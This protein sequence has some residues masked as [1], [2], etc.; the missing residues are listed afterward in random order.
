M[1][2]KNCFEEKRYARVIAIVKSLNEKSQS[3]DARLLAA[4]ASYQL[5]EY[6]A[7]IDYFEK[8]SL[9][10]EDKFTL[11]KAY[12]LS[13]R[14]EKA[15]VTLSVLMQSGEYA[16]KARQDPA[17]SGIVKEI[18]K[19]KTIIKPEI[20]KKSE[21]KNLNRNINPEKNEP[22]GDMKSEDEEE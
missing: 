1:L 14:R 12:A 11:C 6:D 17:L 10:N 9:G 19:D 3:Y 20:E 16:S 5:K 4:K 13:G 8:I 2:A 15:K 18:E 21:E 22:A 7:A